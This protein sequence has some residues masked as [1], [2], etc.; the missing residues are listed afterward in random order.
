[1]FEGSHRGSPLPRIGPLIGGNKRTINLFEGSQSARE[2]AGNKMH[3]SP[4]TFKDGRGEAHKEKYDIPSK[5]SA[6]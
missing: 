2:K 3:V 6:E 1:M 5:P 4:Y